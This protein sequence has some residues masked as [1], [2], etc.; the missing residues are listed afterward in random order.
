VLGAAEFAHVRSRY[1]LITPRW[2]LHL[3]IP[4]EGDRL[5]A[6]ARP[7]AAEMTYRQVVGLPYASRRLTMWWPSAEGPQSYREVLVQ[8]PQSP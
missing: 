7:A 3:A 6:E 2:P 8:T 4:P 5:W 1:S